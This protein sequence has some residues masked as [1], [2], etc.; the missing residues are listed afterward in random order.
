M[1]RLLLLSLIVGCVTVSTLAQSRVKLGYLGE[2]DCSDWTFLSNTSK[3]S[4]REEK[5]VLQTG[6]RCSQSIKIN[7]RK[8]ALTTS[9]TYLP[10]RNWKVGRGGYDVWRGRDTIVRL[11][12]VFT[13]RC[14]PENDNCEV[15]YYRG[16]LDIQYKGLRRRLNVVGTGGS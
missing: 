12:Y 5:A 8:I 1:F 10:E 16:V 4:M 13:W 3:R 9:K 15:Y 14:P 7:G 11:D 2:S 6:H